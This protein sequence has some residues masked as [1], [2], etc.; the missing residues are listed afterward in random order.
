MKKFAMFA[1]FGLTLLFAVSA[2]A[3][4]PEEGFVSLFNGKDL[5]G[6]SG[7]QRLWSVENGEIVGQTDADAKKIVKNTFLV[8]DKS[9]ANFV[10]RFDFKITNPGNSGLQYR[11]WT[12]KDETPFRLGGYQGDFDGGATYS[13]IVYGEGFRGILAERGK[14]CRIGDD[15]KS[16]TVEEFAKNEDLKKE[17]KIEDWNSYEIIADGFHFEHK[18]NG[19]TT[20]ILDDD[21]IQTRRADGVLGIQLHV[22][23]P[24]KV[25]IKNIRMKE[26]K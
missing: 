22:G 14:K 8:S 17:V 23:P 18:I 6:W 13:G 12:I 7:D 20:A 21:D 16:V 2:M 9:F 25:Q 24:M 1:A 11:S 5:T 26:M 15:H 4:N 19:K 3:Q 10:L